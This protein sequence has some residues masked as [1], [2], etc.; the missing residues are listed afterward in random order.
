MDI[1]DFKNA[2]IEPEDARSR[3]NQIPLFTIT[4]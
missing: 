3:N 1:D 4:N 2:I